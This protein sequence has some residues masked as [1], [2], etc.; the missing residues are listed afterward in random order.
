MTRPLASAPVADIAVPSEMRKLAHAPVSL[1]WQNEVGGITG[2]VDGPQPRFIKWNR[3]D[4]GESLAAEARRMRWLS[5]RHPA[6]VVLNYQVDGD[7]ELLVTAALPGLSAVDPVWVAR[8]NDAIR[9]IAD[10]L[11][12]LHALPVSDCPF[13]WGVGARVANAAGSGMAA[14]SE[15]RRAPAID[16]LVVC[17]GDAC[18][19]NT[20]LTD[21]GHFLASVDLGRLGVADRWADLAVAT[22]S[23]GWNYQDFDERVF[24]DAYGIMP[25]PDRIAYYRALWNAS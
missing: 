23:L 16:R 13:D 21:D 20:L 19:P 6:P 7:V 12:T 25:D 1:I 4:S 14:R 8:P 3:L 18:A 17:H 15:L 10:G 9:A 11:R 24:W 5:G 22:M 2:R